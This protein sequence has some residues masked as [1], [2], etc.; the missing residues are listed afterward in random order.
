[1][2]SSPK[3]PKQMKTEPQ[4]VSTAGHRLKE[5]VFAPKEPTI[6]SVGEFLLP[7]LLGAMQA[8][9][10]AAILIGLVSAGL[11]VTSAALI[12]L[13]APFILILGSL[14]LFHYLGIRTQK[15]TNGDSANG[16]KVVLPE[17]SLFL[18]LVGVA[19]LFFIWLNLYSQR[20]FIFDPKWMLLL[21]DDVLLLNG[22]FYE[23]VCIIGLTFLLGWMGIRLINRN[24]EPSDVFRTLWL[25]LGVFIV[26]IVLRTGQARAGAI[27]HN[28]LF[29]LLLIPLFLFLSLMAHALARVVFIRKSHPAGLRGSIVAQE[30]AIILLVGLLGLAFLIFAV[31]IGG[32][33]NSVLLTD[34]EHILAIFGVVYNWLVGVLA[35]IIVIVVIPIFWLLSFLHPSTSNHLPK[36]NRFH[37]PQSPANPAMSAMQEAFAHAIIPILSIILPILFIGIMVLLIRWTLLRRT[38]VGKR[39]NRRNQDVH[40]S[41][42]SW[43][44]FWTQLRSLIRALFARFRHGNMTTEDGVVKIEEIKGEPAVRSIREI[45]RA[46]LQKA[47]RH[48]YPRRRFETPYEFKQRLDEKVPLTEPQ[49]ELITEAYSLTRYGGEAPDEAELAQIRSHWIE[50]DRKWT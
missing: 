35:A 50:L 14:F 46:I 9:W 26:V 42:W 41:L 37:P 12:P 49:L 40:E 16:L 7:Y 17:T 25:G 33:F 45:Y 11:F 47:T 4:S 3:Q 39:A 20:A 32:T 23:A 2:E 19:S 28:D 43:S 1:M 10:I 13:W 8:C 6:S 29:L 44:L 15:N 36:V 18:I 27:V 30:R 48:G 22:Y 5:S 21:F 31:L 38:R 34:L 24:V